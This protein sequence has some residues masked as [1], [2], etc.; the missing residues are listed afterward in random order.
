[1]PFLGVS[2]AQFSLAEH[3]TC[4]LIIVCLLVSC[5]LGCPLLKS[6]TVS[7]ISLCSNAVFGGTLYFLFYTLLNLPIFFKLGMPFLFLIMFITGLNFLN[8]WI[9][10]MKRGERRGDKIKPG[11]K[12]SIQKCVL[13]KCFHLLVVSCS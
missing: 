5:P 10:K 4:L 13:L 7:F 6:Q 9:R 11:M 8:K 3:L 12:L 1:M 2:T